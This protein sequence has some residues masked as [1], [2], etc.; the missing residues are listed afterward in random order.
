MQNNENIIFYFT[1]TGNSLVAARQLADDL[2]T[3]KVISMQEALGCDLSNDSYRRIGFV[4]PV[5]GFG[6]PRIVEDFI[7]KTILPR[8]DYHF[9][10]AS[11]GGNV[12]AT[13]RL[14][15]RLL[16]KRGRQLDAGFA[17]RDPY[18]SLDPLR[19]PKPI[20]VFMS[21]LSGDRLGELESFA[22]RRSEIAT[23]IV[24]EE[25]HSFESTN[26]PADFVGRA[27]HPGALSSFRRESRKFM[28]TEAC[29]C[30]G[31]CARVCPRKNIQLA[32][33]RLEWGNDCEACLACIRWCPSLAIAHADMGD[34]VSTHH[35]EVVRRDF[36]IS[37]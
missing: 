9:A 14:F 1:A 29:T 5:Y 36:V 12:C 16:K 24:A 25:E 3:T 7:K 28:Q 31:T 21:K 27:L 18:Y 6:P 10:V 32:D 8:G 37:R 19:K 20:I 2:G 23:E 33:G 15:A 11:S 17:V 34:I 26:V 35:P 22:V 4:F 30:C 13:N